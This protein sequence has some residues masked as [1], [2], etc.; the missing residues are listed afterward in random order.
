MNSWGKKL[1]RTYLWVFQNTRLIAA[2]ETDH[3]QFMSITYGNLHATLQSNGVA[4][5]IHI[6]RKTVESSSHTEE[7]RQH[8]DATQ[9]HSQ[10]IATDRL[11]STVIQKTSSQI[12]L[13]I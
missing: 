2:K 10:R 4:S 13:S 11:A 3:L 6:T 9:F 8:F 5:T 12:V 1:L 7:K